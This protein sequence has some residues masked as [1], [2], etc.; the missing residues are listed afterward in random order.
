MT[1]EL[2]DEERYRFADGPTTSV[3]TVID[4]PPAAVWPYVIDIGLPAKFSDELV[5]T[6]WLDGATAPALGARFRGTNERSDAGRWQVTCTVV[7]Y[8]PEREFGWVVED[9]ANPAAAWRFTLEP[10]GDGA[11]QLT[12]WVRLGPGPSGLTA[13]L[14]RMPDREHDVISYRLRGLRENMQRN[15]DGIAEL[16]QGDPA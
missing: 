8:E 7:E 16:A 11:T 14:E 5:E 10:A 13:A 3:S 6:E 9:P 4:A 2:T 1:D 15:L 12:Q